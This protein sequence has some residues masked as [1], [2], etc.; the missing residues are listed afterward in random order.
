ML[1]SSPLGWGW[2]SPHL[3][4]FMAISLVTLRGAIPASASLVPNDLC[5]WREEQE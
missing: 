2:S 5:G 1:L 4:F 3:L